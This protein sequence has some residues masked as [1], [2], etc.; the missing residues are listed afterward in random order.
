MR[1]DALFLCLLITLSL[2]YF[3]LFFY[4]GFEITEKY[5][6]EIQKV[7]FGI[8]SNTANAQINE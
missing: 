8:E 4:N 7:L 6:L 1:K 2:I 3:D 5:G